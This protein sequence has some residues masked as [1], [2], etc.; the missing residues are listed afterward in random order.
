MPKNA[1]KAADNVFYLARKAAEKCNDHLGSREGAAEETGIDRTRLARIEAGVLVPYPEEVLMMAHTYQA[2]Q[3]CNH[4]CASLCPLGKKT[5]PPCELLQIDRLAL[6][7]MS[8]MLLSGSNTSIEPNRSRLYRGQNFYRRLCPPV[9]CTLRQPS[10]AFLHRC[11]GDYLSVAPT[12][13][14]DCP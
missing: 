12:R 10:R 13:H 1:T 8:A 9:R 5:I 14:R 7:V 2:P 6:K 3:L 11:F 4:Y